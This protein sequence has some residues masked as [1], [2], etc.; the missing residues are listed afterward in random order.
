[1]LLVVQVSEMSDAV[2]LL[3]EAVMEFTQYMLQ[4]QVIVID[5]HTILTCH[6]NDGRAQCLH[7]C[8]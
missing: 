5:V 6:V 2:R 3:A 1:M 8:N 4:I 7:M